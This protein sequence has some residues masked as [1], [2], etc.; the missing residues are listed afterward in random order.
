MMSQ[1]ISMPLTYS[2][3]EEI[4]WTDLTCHIKEHKCP[5][6]KKEFTEILDFL[7]EQNCPHGTPLFSKNL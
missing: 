2:N 1:T 6:R 4:F 7:I 5:F 3:A